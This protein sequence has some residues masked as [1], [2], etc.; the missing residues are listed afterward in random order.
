[1]W[2][3]KTQTNCFLDYYSPP[4]NSVCLKIISQPKHV[5]W[6]LEKTFAQNIK[7]GA[8]NIKKGLLVNARISYFDSECPLTV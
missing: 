3:F 6:V 4:D 2:V 8:Q 7:N 1:M 5:L